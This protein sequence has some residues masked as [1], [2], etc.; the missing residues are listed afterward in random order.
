M[1]PGIHE[2]QMLASFDLDIEELEQRL[3][4]ATTLHVACYVNGANCD[5]NCNGNCASNCFS[6]G[7]A[8]HCC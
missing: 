1:E 5:T 2:I 6:D 3:E 8:S 4:L 7:C